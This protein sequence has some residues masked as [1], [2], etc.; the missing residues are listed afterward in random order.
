M[1]DNY[2]SEQI[3]N[4]DETSLFWKKMTERT[5][6][7]KE[8][9]SMPGFTVCVSTP[10]DIYMMTKLPNDAFIRTYPVVK[11]RMT[12]FDYGTTFYFLKIL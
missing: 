12:V 5:F 11:R 8:A 1:E 4:T 2:L 7:H 10:C 6:I 3:F 9:K